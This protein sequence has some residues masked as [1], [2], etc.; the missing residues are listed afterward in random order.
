MSQEAIPSQEMTLLPSNG[1]GK[2]S[3]QAKESL[4]ELLDS[5]KA[6]QDN[7]GQICELTA[8]E[9]NLVEAFFESLFKLMQPLTTTIPVSPRALPE[10]MGKVVQANVDPTGHLIILHD[11]GHVESK[12]LRAEANRDLMIPVIKDV[13]PKFKP[14]TNA[15]RQKI[16]HRI[17]FLTSVTRELQKMSEAFSA[18]NTQ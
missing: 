9:R 10:K 8:E 6:V 7:I 3:K 11:D 17:K 5:L 1:G 14:L 12:N 18:T 13:I 15:H 2:E 4:Q 16:E